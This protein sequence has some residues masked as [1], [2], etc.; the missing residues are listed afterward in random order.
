MKSILSSLIK[1]VFGPSF[2]QLVSIWNS[3]AVIMNF[4]GAVL[5]I[6]RKTVVSRQGNDDIVTKL[7]WF[8][9]HALK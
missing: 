3:D 9:F 7:K 1:R 2:G 4:C 5:P 6:C 8:L